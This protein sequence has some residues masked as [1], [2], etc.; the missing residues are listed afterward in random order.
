MDALEAVIDLVKQNEELAHTV[1]MYEEW[2]EGLVGRAVTITR[3]HKKKTEFITGEVEEFEPGEGWIVRC[4]EN[5]EVMTLTFD[6]IMDGR[7]WIVKKPP[8]V[9]RPKRSVHF[10][11]QD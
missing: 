3:T 11:A 6:D 7:A 2:F 9:Q 1:D 4:I 10:D 5:D 8:P